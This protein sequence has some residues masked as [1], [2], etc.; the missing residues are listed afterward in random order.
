MSLIS[1][2]FSDR[3]R[4][5]QTKRQEK[6]ILTESIRD[7]C[8]EL[9]KGLR[10]RLV[11][12]ILKCPSDCYINLTLRAPGYSAWAENALMERLTEKINKAVAKAG[13]RFEEFKNI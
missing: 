8:G 9:D 11:K 1:I 2:I 6:R 3:Y 10:R 13:R 12:R 5:F 4:H 7:C